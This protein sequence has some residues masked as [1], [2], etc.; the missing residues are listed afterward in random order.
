MW[1]K[2]ILPMPVLLLLQLHY[3]SHMADGSA[4][5]CPYTLLL[6]SC[7]CDTLNIT[8]W[9]DDLVKAIVLLYIT[10]QVAW[11][12]E[13]RQVMCLHLELPRHST[14]LQHNHSMYKG[15]TLGTLQAMTQLRN[16][17]HPVD[18]RLLRITSC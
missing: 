18:L 9:Y 17:L 4:L 10:F 15:L 3:C 1:Y 8:T 6:V 14:E 11:P 16:G 13:R 12:I 2:S 7:S 5:L